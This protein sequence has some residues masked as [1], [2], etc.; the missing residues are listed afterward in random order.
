MK[1]VYSV[2]RFL[3]SKIIRLAGSIF[4]LSTGENGC[5]WYCG[6]VVA[7][8]CAVANIAKPDVLSL[9]LSS[10]KNEQLWFGGCY[11]YTGVK[12]YEGLELSALRKDFYFS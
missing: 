6:Q 8:R 2:K 9:C 5:K 1:N 10:G 12:V 3:Y 7:L 4:G 11:L